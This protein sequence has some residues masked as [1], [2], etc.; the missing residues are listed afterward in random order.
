MS[1]Y[2]YGWLIFVRATYKV[3]TKK[4]GAGPMPW[5]NALKMGASYRCAVDGQYRKPPRWPRYMQK[6]G[7]RDDR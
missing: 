3:R 2:L 1:R 5:G 6:F 4:H 7:V